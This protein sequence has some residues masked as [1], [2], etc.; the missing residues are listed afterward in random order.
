MFQRALVVA[1]FISGV[2]MADAQ[3]TVYSEPVAAVD[4]IPPAPVA[5]LQALVAM[6]AGGRSV[7]LTWSLSSDDALSFQA[8]VGGTVVLLGDVRG[9]RV[10]RT[11]EGGNE[12]LLATL[13]SGISEYVDSTVE[14]GQSYIYS[15][16]SFDLDNE[17][18][19]DAVAGS[20]A[21]LARIVLVGGTTQV[22]VGNDNQG[23]HAH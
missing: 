8:S 20:D 6:D 23:I 16:R 5:D 13:S 17:T 19:I 4:N 3:L 21:D 18:E 15:V 10:Y 22:V 7:E 2:H 1:M 11:D 14:D 9:Y 12:L